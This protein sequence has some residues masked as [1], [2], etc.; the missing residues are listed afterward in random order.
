MNIGDLQKRVLVEKPAIPLLLDEFPNAAAAYSLRL[1]RTAYTGNCIEVRRSS[2]NALQNI[3]FVNGVLDTA[4]LLSFVGAGDGFVRTWYDQSGNNRNAV[5]TT[6]DQQPKVVNSN[7]LITE[8]SKVSASFDGT[9]DNLEITNF[10]TDNYTNI[11]VLSVQKATRVS[12]VNSIFVKY[13]TTNNNRSFLFSIRDNNLSI[14]ATQTGATP[15]FRVDSSGENVNDFQL[16]ALTFRGSESPFINK[17]DYWKNSLNTL[18]VLVFSTEVTSLPNTNANF[19]IGAS[20]TGLNLNFEGNISEIVFY[21]TSQ[22]N[23]I[24]NMHI[25]SN[26]Y[27]NIF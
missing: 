25:L 2:D 5:N 16:S 1:L 24:P 13:L 3:G 6:P 21:E 26:K 23:N 9:N 7:V 19:F 18:K 4:S 14:N 12:G 27:Y 8:N 15:V 11:S 17:I 10:Q 22:F 20:D